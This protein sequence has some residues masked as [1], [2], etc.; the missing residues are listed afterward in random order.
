SR[1]RG[2][3]ELR[4]TR[5]RRALLLGLPAALRRGAEASARGDRRGPGRLAGALERRGCVY[6][7]VTRARGPP[8]TDLLV[9]P[10]AAPLVGSVPAPAD[11]EIAQLALAVAAIAEG[12]SRID[13]GGAVAGDVR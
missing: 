11:V 8:V 10:A 5:R 1:V 7:I 12:R 3:D 4:G 13:L 6:R 9:Y 2:A